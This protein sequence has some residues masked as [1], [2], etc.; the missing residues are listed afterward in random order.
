L[1]ILIKLTAL[2][3]IFLHANINSTDL[4]FQISIFSIFSLITNAFGFVFL[5]LLLFFL[6]LIS[7]LD[8]SSTQSDGQSVKLLKLNSHLRLFQ[9][10]LVYLVDIIINNIQIHI[11]AI[12]LVTASDNQYQISYPNILINTTVNKYNQIVL[13]LILSEPIP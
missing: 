2:I 5:L 9:Y 4:I 12:T 13:Y 8:S 10:F 1:T 6:S 3:F 11:K 7:S